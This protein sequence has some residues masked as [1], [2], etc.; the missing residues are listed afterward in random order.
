MGTGMFLFL[1]AIL[2][3]LMLFS[4]SYRIYKIEVFIDN[5]IRHNQEY[6]DSEGVEED[7]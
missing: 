6:A 3:L 7:A 4:I 1:Y 5:L 2:S